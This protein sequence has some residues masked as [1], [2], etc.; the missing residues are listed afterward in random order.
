MTS[1]RVIYYLAESNKSVSTSFM[2][3]KLSIDGT[4]LHHVSMCLVTIIFMSED[5]QCLTVRGCH[6]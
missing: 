2:N 6:N 1:N 4:S 3:C 5:K